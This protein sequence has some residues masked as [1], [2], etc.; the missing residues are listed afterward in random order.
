MASSEK[1][2]SLCV[3][4]VNVNKDLITKP[5]TKISVTFPPLQSLEVTLKDNRKKYADKVQ[6]LLWAW[7]QVTNCMNKDF[8]LAVFEF[9]HGQ[10]LYLVLRGDWPR[11]APVIQTHLL[12]LLQKCLKYLKAKH[13]DSSSISRCSSLMNLVSDPWG[14]D[15]LSK[16]I[17][18]EETTDKE[19]M[20]YC[21][22]EKGDLIMIRL[23]LLI[24]SKCEDMALNLAGAA[25]RW[26]RVPNSG[27]ETNSTNDQRNFFLDVYLTTLCRFKKNQEIILE[28]KSLDLEQGLELIRR[29][30][31][32][33]WPSS[34]NSSLSSSTSSARIW[35]HGNRVAEIAVN[36][37]LA[38]AMVQPPSLHLADLVLEWAIIHG[39]MMKSSPQT[40]FDM[41]KKFLMTAL[42]EEHVYIFSEV[43]VK[44]FGD[45]VK[46][47]CIEFCIRFLS[48]EMNDLLQL[49]VKPD[50]EKQREIEIKLS[51]GFLK[52]ANLVGS[53][54]TDIYRE[55]VLTGFSLNPTSNTLDIIKSLGGK[56]EIPPLDKT[57]QIVAESECNLDKPSKPD[58]TDDDIE[59]EKDGTNQM[60]ME[61]V[62][63]SKDIGIAD[64][65]SETSQV[66]QLDTH[67]EHESSHVDSNAN[68]PSNR[69]SPEGTNTSNFEK[70]GNALGL[71][72]HLMDDLSI[73]IRGSRYQALNWDNDWTELKCLCEDYLIDFRKF[74]ETNKELKYLKIDYDQ[75]KDWPV[76]KE[77]DKHNGIE[78][79]YEK[80]IEGTDDSDESLSESASCS[81][82]I[83]DSD[84]ESCDSF[85]LKKGLKR[86]EVSKRRSDSDSEFEI[87]KY[88]SKKKRK[89]CKKKV[90]IISDSDNGTLDSVKSICSASRKNA[91][92]KKKTKN[93]KDNR[94]ETSRPRKVGRPPKRIPSP[95]DDSISNEFKFSDNENDNNN[96]RFKKILVSE[97]FDENES[98]HSNLLKNESKKPVSRTHVLK[99][100]RTFRKT[101]PDLRQSSK[102]G[103]R[104]FSDVPEEEYSLLQ[105][106]PTRTFA[107][108]SI[109]STINFNNPS[110]SSKMELSDG[111]DDDELSDN[112][113]YTFTEDEPLNSSTKL[114]PFTKIDKNSKIKLDGFDFPR[115][116]KSSIENTVSE[117]SSISN[118]VPSEVRATVQ[119]VQ[120][121]N[122]TSSTA[123][124][125]LLSRQQSSSDKPPQTSSTSA[126]NSAAQS[127]TYSSPV[128]SQTSTI[129]ATKIHD[130][131]TSNTESQPT[132]QLFNS[133]PNNISALI[134]CSETQNTSETITLQ[135][136]EPVTMSPILRVPVQTPNALIIQSQAVDQSNKPATSSNTVASVVK[137][138]RSSAFV[139]VASSDSTSSI[140]RTSAVSQQQVQQ[141]LISLANSSFVG[142]NND[143]NTATLFK[144]D[145]GRK[146]ENVVQLTVS[147]DSRLLWAQQI[148]NIKR[149]ESAGQTVN[150]VISQSGN[151]ANPRVVEAKDANLEAQ[152]AS[153][154]QPA[155]LRLE[156]APNIIKT[157]SP[158][159]QSTQ[160]ASLPKFQQAFGKTM[161]QSVPCPVVGGNISESKVVNVLEL[162]QAQIQRDNLLACPVVSKGV[163]TSKDPNSSLQKAESSDVA[164]VV[165]KGENSNS[166]QVSTLIPQTSIQVKTPQVKTSAIQTSPGVIV[167]CKRVALLKE[168]EASVDTAPAAK[169]LETKPVK[170]QLRL[171]DLLTAAIQSPVQATTSGPNVINIINPLNQTIQISNSTDDAVKGKNTATTSTARLTLPSIIQK[172]VGRQTVLQPSAYKFKPFQLPLSVRSAFLSTITNINQPAN[173][174]TTPVPNQNQSRLVSRES[175]VIRNRIEAT[176]GAS[177]M[178]SSTTAEQLTARGLREF[179][180]VLEK[181]T[182][183]SQMKERINVQLHAPLDSSTSSNESSSAGL[184]AA[185]SGPPNSSAPTLTP[186]SSTMEP[187]DRVVSFVTQTSSCGSLT[188]GTKLNTTPVVV[189]Q[190]YRRQASSPAL[191]IASQNS[192]SPIPSSSNKTQKPAT[193][194]SKAKIVKTSPVTSP[195]KVTPSI[196]KPQQKPQEDEQTTQRIY[197]ILDK[198]AEQLRNSPE[199]KNKPA[200][201]RRSNPP[202]NPTQSSKRK[203]S[204]QSRSR[205]NSQQASCSLG[206]DMSPSS[207][208]VRTLGSEDS[209]NGVSQ[210]SQM[211]S[212]PSSRLDETPATPSSETSESLDARDT[213]IQIQAQPQTQTQPV[214]TNRALIVQDSTLS[215]ADAAKIFG[216]QSRQQTVVSSSAG[217]PLP[218]GTVRLL[219]TK[220]PKMYKIQQMVPM[221]L[222]PGLAKIAGGL[223]AQNIGGQQAVVLPTGTRSFTFTE[224]TGEQQTVNLDSSVIPTSIN[225]LQLHGTNSTSTNISAITTVASA[226]LPKFSA[227][228]PESSTLSDTT[229]SPNVSQFSLSQSSSSAPSQIVLD[230]SNKE[231]SIWSD[232]SSV[233][234]K[235]LFLEL[236]KSTKS[237]KT[238]AALFSCQNELK[239]DIRNSSSPNQLKQDSRIESTLDD[240]DSKEDVKPQATENLLLET[241]EIKKEIKEEEDNQVSTCDDTVH[242]QQYL[243]K[244]D[245]SQGEK[246]PTMNQTVSDIDPCNTTNATLTLTHAKRKGGSLHSTLFQSN[247]RRSDRLQTGKR[248]DGL[249]KKAELKSLSEECKDLGVDKPSA[250]DLFPEAELLL[251]LDPSSQEAEIQLIM[252]PESNYNNKDSGLNFSQGDGVSN[253]KTYARSNLKSKLKLCSSPS[254]ILKMCSDSD[255][256]IL[257]QSELYCSPDEKT[258][259]KTGVSSS[260]SSQGGCSSHQESSFGSQP[261]LHS[262]RDGPKSSHSSNEGASCFKSKKRSLSKSRSPM[263]CRSDKQ[264]SNS[265]PP[266]PLDSSVNGALDLD[267]DSVDFKKSLGSL[268][269]DDGKLPE[270]SPDHNYPSPTTPHSSSDA[271]FSSDPQLNMLDSTSN[272]F[273]CSSSQNNFRSRSR[274]KPSHDNQESDSFWSL[275]K[276]SDHGEDV[277]SDVDKIATSDA[278]DAVS[279]GEL[280]LSSNGLGKRRSS[281]SLKTA[282]SKVSKI[283][284]E[285]LDVTSSA[286]SPEI[287]E[288]EKPRV[289]RRLSSRGLVKKPCPCCN[290]SPE[291]PK[292]KNHP[293]ISSSSCS[294]ASK[295]GHNSK[296]QSLLKS[297]LK[298]R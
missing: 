172:T 292:R 280:T 238:E 185:T 11:L 138:A 53:S 33:S 58:Q 166:H 218:P 209:S 46:P 192:S 153:S 84:F 279:E 272:P 255:S 66:S 13:A 235:P 24:V 189:V 73:V 269:D 79:G 188:V 163:Q 89:K 187:Q 39:P 6:A 3:E 18:G 229:S 128:I 266:L 20:E 105:D 160:N 119:V 200:P 167:A 248:S 41:I 94:K 114:E 98:F 254:S 101:K 289:P 104:Y 118:L 190:S 247:Y 151:F 217:V 165:V 212:S 184:A 241:S 275:L 15:T 232:F 17:H 37:F 253:L 144:A 109:A 63:K 215:S 103:F 19:V 182:K 16:L 106:S 204:S 14:H 36:T 267:S 178:E 12:V 264:S 28:L 83:D 270:S 140:A 116:N 206:L 121:T 175:P 276:K 205:S 141:T 179:E 157:R 30:A 5:S 127:N 38:S 40:F 169:K 67:N 208:D 108:N 69:L 54:Y 60:D 183:T 22:A 284:K 273:I 268:I 80:W 148:G 245:A 251:D 31:S 57:E 249:Q 88:R 250:S 130:P 196:P 240:A 62:G 298:R 134:E 258:H 154:S 1:M 124:P 26:M 203:K 243:S 193:K 252:N 156:S 50:E 29:Y 113:K 244:E 259:L 199:L 44:Q 281:S 222:R 95:A 65:I 225:L 132:L 221:V 131:S 32:P 133:I 191:S 177:S 122:H 283:A 68:D 164:Q 56:N 125:T 97:S 197:A 59:P 45:I 42:S 265:E 202:T 282:K 78:K 87:G 43:L 120:V 176:V 61:L 286:S 47:I 150:V 219:V 35:R 27:C 10:T 155:V 174:V 233:D 287:I 90:K 74:R 77:K 216:T 263:S 159:T 107:P 237:V 288:G 224:G 195:L 277:D 86:K 168:P 100:L 295:K 110:L 162:N 207:E 82:S 143:N 257:G 242:W 181:V 234:N 262:Q 25:V 81:Q 201:R 227:A 111:Y 239:D 285:D 49:K 7:E 102:L 2:S 72:R 180:S 198:Y 294:S 223:T 211:T 71:T 194:S 170:E 246:S 230:T 48:A 85:I 4:N 51:S 91:S 161:Y 290:G 297:A 96:S 158:I 21:Q 220:A 75:F 274:L 186:S 171:N 145:D 296:S 64:E 260:S 139:F 123:N 149:S 293:H 8:S 256:P 115:R 228:V 146:N 52:L 291:Q 76:D 210:L 34:Y 213:R 55:C 136:A 117:L 271:I 261:K 70:E 99:T 135:R 9:M 126:Q 92:K 236:R 231:R 93:A 137:P 173:T 129:S 23:E 147:R 152:K 142:T 278:E 112:C 214:T 226:N